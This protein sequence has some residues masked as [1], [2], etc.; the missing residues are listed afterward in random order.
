MNSNRHF[1][2]NLRSRYLNRRHSLRRRLLAIL[3]AMFLITLLL[4]GASVFY[5]IFQNEQ[6]TW[7]ER[8]VEAARHAR[9]DARFE[10]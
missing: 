1:P 6:R 3:G 10:K 9:C 7:Q 8:Q 5:F 4:I 2:T